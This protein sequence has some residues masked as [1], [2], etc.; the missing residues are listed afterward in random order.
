MKKRKW[1]QTGLVVSTVVVLY[2]YELKRR[3]KI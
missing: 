1:I 3:K 2:L